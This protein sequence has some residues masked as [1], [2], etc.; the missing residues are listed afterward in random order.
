VLKQRLYSIKAL[1]RALHRDHE[2]KHRG[3]FEFVA[4]WLTLNQ[5]N[6]C[7][8]VDRGLRRELDATTLRATVDFLDAQQFGLQ[9][10]R[11][12]AYQVFGRL[13]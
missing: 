3:T 6:Q 7:Q 8:R 4:F 1:F 11:G 13:R 2:F 5:F 12:N 10:Q 9:L